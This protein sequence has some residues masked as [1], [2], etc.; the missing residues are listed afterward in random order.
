MGLRSISRL[1]CLLGGLVLA[2]GVA[3]ACGVDERA[4]GLAPADGMSANGENADGGAGASGC[5]PRDC[6]SPFDNDCDGKPDDTLDDACRCVPGNT[7]PCDVPPE[8]NVGSC[9]AGSSEC[10][11]DASGGRSDWSSCVGARAVQPRNCNSELDNDCNGHADNGECDCV[12]GE[13]RS[14][15]AAPGSFGCT[16]GTE[17]CVAGVGG[18]STWAACEFV[19]E[20]D[21]VP[22][23][24]ENPRSVGDA[25]LAGSCES[26]RDDLLAVGD[27][28]S[29]AVTRA[30][31]LSCWGNLSPGQAGG[32]SPAPTTLAGGG[33]VGV[34]AGGGTACALRENR[35]VACFLDN[36]FGERGNGAPSVV[37]DYGALTDVVSL[38]SVQYIS[39]GFRN[40]AALDGAG[41]VWVWGEGQQAANIELF[42]PLAP[43][44]VLGPVAS[45]ET[46]PAPHRVRSLGNVALISVGTFHACALRVDG[47]VACWGRSV[48]GDLGVPGVAASAAPVEVAGLGPVATLGSGFGTCAVEVSGT[49]QCWGIACPGGVFDAFCAAPTAVA[50]ISDALQVATSGTATCVLERSGQVLCWGANNEGQL[51]DGTTMDRTTPG[52]V[53]GLTDAVLLARG[54]RNAHQ[55]ALRRNGEVVC[56]GYNPYGQVGDGSTTSSLTPV[57]VSGLDPV[58]PER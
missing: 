9:Q 21:E 15:G 39:S 32:E 45:Y 54:G 3:A 27:N 4:V 2:A 55:C 33:F 41:L 47:S 13:T 19:P 8:G 20:A 17:T 22:C 28:I 43:T 29:C 5:T 30:G 23:N 46:V 40:N 38:D 48:F 52:P 37:T 51:G 53:T 26:R 11:L 25:C 35:T 1:D 57:V 34:T 49:V 14:C 16:R 24:D 56:W 44:I 31:A 50:G 58:G 36:L 18:Q 10:L 7:M 42:G 12:P 6:R